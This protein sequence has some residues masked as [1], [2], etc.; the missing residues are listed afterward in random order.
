VWLFPFSLFA[1][2]FII[3]ALFDQKKRGIGLTLAIFSGLW[4]GY[5][6]FIG[7]DIFPAHRHIIPILVVMTYALIEGTDWLLSRWPRPLPRKIKFVLGASLLFSMLLFVI[8]QFFDPMNQRAVTERWEWDCKI[9]GETLNG[10]FFDEQPL[11]A[12]TA[13]GCLPY[14]SHL[15]ALDMLGLND[16]YLPRHPPEDF[17]HGVLAH[18]LGDGAYVLSQHP[19]II[20]F[21]IGSK[22]AHF[23]S[24]VEM[25]QM[26]EFYEHYTPIK[27]LDDDYLATVW[28]AKE[29][30]RIGIKK[31]P[32]E[33][34]IPAY[35]FN[36]NPDT[37]AYLNNAG[38]LVVAVQ[39][40]R[41]IGVTLDNIPEEDWEVEIVASS[42]IREHELH[43]TLQHSGDSLSLAITT[44]SQEP[45][46]IETVVLRKS[47]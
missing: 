47:D 12:V 39:A 17:G 40:G 3:I 6:I 41:P 8:V 10:A 45:I 15:P 9:L 24:G 16:Y 27:I 19:D 44:P 18:E 21:H 38:K 23:L 35:F 36:D 25:Q 31:T 1:G 28:L 46:E 29:S 5:V 7:G 43:T 22:T 14:W 4:G 13:A 11:M 30:S 34:Y 2:I 26:D 32:T 33:I 20:V 37:V 42:P